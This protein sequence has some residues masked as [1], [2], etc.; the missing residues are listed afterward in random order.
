MRRNASCT[1]SL[2]EAYRPVATWA[3]MNL[4]SSSVSETLIF[5]NGLSFLLFWALPPCSARAAPKGRRW[6]SLRSTHP[7]RSFEDIPLLPLPHYAKVQAPDQRCSPCFG[8]PH[9]GI[10][11]PRRRGVRPVHDGA[12]NHA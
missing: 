2:E 10:D 5:M 3:S 8:I 11:L 9:R 12:A 1:T 4:A 7:R 6:V